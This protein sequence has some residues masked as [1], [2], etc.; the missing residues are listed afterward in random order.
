MLETF[1][2]TFSF[3]FEK[4]MHWKRVPVFLRFLV[5]PGR[6]T[7]RPHV[8]SVRACAVETHVLLFD[9]LIKHS[10]NNFQLG[11]DLGTHFGQK[12]NSFAKK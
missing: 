2:D 9:R 1:F 5:R 4:H 3:S 7:A 11:L 12:V 8:Q 6:S 10:S